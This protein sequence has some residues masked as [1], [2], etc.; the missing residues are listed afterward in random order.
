M[1]ALRTS[2]DKDSRNSDKRTPRDRVFEKLVFCQIVREF[3]ALY[4]NPSFIT[5]FKA[6]A[7]FLVLSQINPVHAPVTVLADQF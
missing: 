7:I 5:K 2:E 3:L 1:S 4:G 6:H